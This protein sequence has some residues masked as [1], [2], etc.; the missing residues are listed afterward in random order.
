MEAV[1]AMEGHGLMQ[2]MTTVNGHE[3]RIDLMESG[4]ILLDGA[5]YVLDLESVDGGFHYSVLAGAASY[6]IFVEHCDDVC[7]VNIEGQRYQVRVQDEAQRL[8]EVQARRSSLG[9]GMTEVTS[10]MPGVVVAVL[11]EEGQLVRTGEGLAILEAMKMENEIRAPLNGVVQGVNVV[12][13]QRVSQE[14]SL[15]QIGP[16]TA[17]EQS[18]EGEADG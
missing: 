14:E 6:E 5:P 1:R 13:G 10:P 7:F 12:A 17:A 15:M 2:Y 3:Y 9:M 18:A 11:V 16:A 8:Q 4:E